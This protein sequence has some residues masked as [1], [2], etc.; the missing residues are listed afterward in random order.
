MWTHYFSCGLTS[1]EGR[2]LLPLP[3]GNAL[4]DAA[5]D[6]ISQEAAF[7]A[8]AYCWLTFFGSIRTSCSFSQ[9]AFQLVSLQHILVPGLVPPQVQDFAL[10]L[11]N[12]MR[13]LS[14]HFSSLC[15]SIWMHHNPLVCWPS[16]SV[17]RHQQP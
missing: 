11:L 2:V 15:K 6:T 5:Q 17:L 7:S 16:L 4:P 8:G 13:F 12:C 3:V 14:A 9:A 1:A 10:P